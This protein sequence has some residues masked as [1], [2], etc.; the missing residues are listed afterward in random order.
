MRGWVAGPLL[1]F[2]TETTGVSPVEHRIVSAALVRREGAASRVRTWLLDPG[3]PIPE[4]ASAVHGITTAQ[5]A[6]HGRPAAE[7]LEEL[8]A[9]LA[10][11]LAAGVPVVAFNAAYDLTLLEAELA[12]HG[13]APLADRLGGAIGPVLDPL[14]LDRALTGYR[15]GRRR[16]VDLCAAYGLEPSG[17]LHTAEVDVV[18]TLDVLAAI[19][20]R[21]PAVALMPPGQLHAWQATTHRAW[22]E[23]FAARGRI[24]G[25]RGP[26]PERRWPLGQRRE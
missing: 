19:A 21:H 16:L 6:E 20:E 24:R 18:T 7:A 11:D 8:A 10:A 26:G 17:A 2:D 13:L 1:G 25:Y 5:V 15:P 9:A 12:R 23:R 4:G 3:V 14:V 22:A